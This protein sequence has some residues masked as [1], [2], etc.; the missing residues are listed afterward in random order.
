VADG[1]VGR[2]QERLV[3]F[4]A[5]AHHLDEAEALLASHQEDLEHARRQLT[6]DREAIEEQAEADRRRMAD[7]RAAMLDELNEQK[8]ALKRRG[9][10]I[11]ARRAAVRQLQE[12]V[13][14]TQRET[15]EMRLATE[16][17][18]ARL[19]GTMAPAALTRS[20][21][22]IRGQLADQNRLV[23]K[24]MAE[25]K[26][27][28]TAL[29]AQLDQRHSKLSGKRQELQTWLERRQRE[30]EK[31]ASVLVKREQELDKQEA[32]FKKR[33]R[34]WEAERHDYQKE[35]RR[36]LRQLRRTEAAAA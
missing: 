20:L 19:C 3:H 31:Q 24:D 27:E 29:A 7:E 22:E 17:L 11:D 8:Q 6:I 1:D 13:A 26:A 23:L 14:R 34:E 5:R 25:Q 18:W 12:E 9:D 16:E 32:H 35:I 4:Q 10:E 33:A 15:L 36:L 21:A 2:L 30:I 28:L